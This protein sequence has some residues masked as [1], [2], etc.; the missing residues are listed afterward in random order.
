L[1]VN[2]A[3][4]LSAPPSSSRAP[5]TRCSAKPDGAA[6]EGAGSS[7]RIF[8]FDGEQH[9]FREA[10]TIRRAL[11]AE[12]AFFATLVLRSGLRF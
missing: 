8:L 4:R 2:H 3:E 6:S 10:E 9:G 7:G 12:L 5:T 1:R 11:D